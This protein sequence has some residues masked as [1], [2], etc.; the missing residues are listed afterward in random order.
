MTRRSS[1]M[2]SGSRGPAACVSE[3]RPEGR[4][5]RTGRRSFVM[6]AGG[7]Q[8]SGTGVLMRNVAIASVMMLILAV[9]ASAQ[10][11]DTILVNA[12]V[13]TVDASFSQQE[14]LAV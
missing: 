11:A 3:R 9:P 10:Q 14:A 13:L 5:Y 6:V 4:D 7:L 2:T 1:V 8:A 12:K